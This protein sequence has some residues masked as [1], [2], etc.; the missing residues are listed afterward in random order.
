MRSRNSN[1]TARESARQVDGRFGVQPRDEAN[2][3]VLDAADTSGGSVIKDA[4]PL[5][6]EI[7]AINEQWNDELLCAEIV[8][9]LDRDADQNDYDAR[10]VVRIVLNPVQDT[11]AHTTYL[12]MAAGPDAEPLGSFSVPGR[13]FRDGVV[14]ASFS[15]AQTGH[16]GELDVAAVRDHDWTAGE[17]RYRERIVAAVLGEQY[18]LRLSFAW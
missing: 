12:P 17:L 9:A 14:P 4:R 7:A 8:A 16:D 10:R 5:V 18:H 3:V 1:A 11:S 13:A 6:D 15:A 2:D